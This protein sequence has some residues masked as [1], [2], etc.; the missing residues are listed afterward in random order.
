M[1]FTFTIKGRLDSMN[2]TDRDQRNPRYR[3]FG[4]LRRKRVKQ[5]VA[6]CILYNRVPTFSGTVKVHI[7]WVEKDKRRDI[8]NIRSGA[9]VILDSLVKMGRIR[10]DSQKWLTALT[11]NYEVNK[12]NPR[13]EVT[14]EDATPAPIQESLSELAMPEGSD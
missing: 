14:I 4:A 6:L 9:K 1:K 11:D 7:R 2:T 5:Q 12:E 10:N 13:I 3:F 8:D